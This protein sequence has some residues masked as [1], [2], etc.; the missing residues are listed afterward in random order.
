MT[1]QKRREI[2]FQKLFLLFLVIAYR[3]AQKSL[4]L[5]YS[6]VLTGMFRLKPSIKFIE[7]HHSLVCF[8]PK[9]EDHISKKNFVNSVSNKG[10]PRHSLGG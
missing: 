3:V 10:G 8:A 1:L 7:R 2:Q 9:L 6:L 5:K 4:N